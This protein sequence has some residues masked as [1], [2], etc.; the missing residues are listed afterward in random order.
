MKYSVRMIDGQ[1]SNIDS[2]GYSLY[3]KELTVKFKSNDV[4]V[5]YDVPQNKF[6]SMINA[7]S[8]GKY[9][10]KNIREK[11]SSDKLTD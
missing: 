10:I 8:R 4:Y 6:I 11:Y 5:Y 9:F 3:N 1:S 2:F 7:D